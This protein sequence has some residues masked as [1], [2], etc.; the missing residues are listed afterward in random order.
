MAAKFIKQKLH[1]ALFTILRE[2]A[3]GVECFQYNSPPNQP[4]PNIVTNL[5]MKEQHFMGPVDNWN[6][7]A[8]YG[9]FQI[10]ICYDTTATFLSI[11]KM[12]EDIYTAFYRKDSHL[13][14]TT[15]PVAGV[16]NVQIEPVSEGENSYIAE[17]QSVYIM[18]FIIQG[19]K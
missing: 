12:A 1:D 7:D 13:H 17:Q 16:T 10:N 4:V 8:F 11:Q 5:M 18:L 6:N 19:T 14:Q 9:I 2:K 3:K 15:L